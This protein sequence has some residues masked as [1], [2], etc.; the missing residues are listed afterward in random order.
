[1]LV[2]LL[3][4]DLSLLVRRRVQTN[5]PTFH[6]SPRLRFESLCWFVDDDDIVDDAQADS[7]LEY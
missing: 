5:L 1:M 2:H 7:F 3:S 6:R 4:I